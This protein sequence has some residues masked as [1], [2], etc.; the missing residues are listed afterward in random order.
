MHGSFDKLRVRAF[1]SLAII[2][3]EAVVEEYANE[4]PSTGAARLQSFITGFRSRVGSVFSFEHASNR[5]ATATEGD[6]RAT[7]EQLVRSTVRSRNRDPERQCIVVGS[8]YETLCKIL[9]SDGI[10]L[11]GNPRTTLMP[12]QQPNFTSALHH[13]DVHHIVVSGT[14]A[15]FE[16]LVALLTSSHSWI[17]DVCD[18]LHGLAALINHFISELKARD[19]DALRSSGSLIQERVMSVFG[20]RCFI[21]RTAAETGIWGERITASASRRLLAA[22][23]FGLG[24]PSLPATQIANEIEE[25]DGLKEVDGKPLGQWIDQHHFGRINTP[26]SME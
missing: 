6:P 14:E 12:K 1:L 2:D 10:L 18:Q 16:R 3:W 25:A 4:Q 11:F 24:H 7:M 5:I 26:W 13:M 19:F 23:Q 8:R 17:R 21:E 9:D 20:D 15:E 22:A